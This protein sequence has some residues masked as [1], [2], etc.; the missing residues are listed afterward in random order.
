MQTDGL[1]DL[2]VN[3]YAGADFNDAAITSAQVDHALEAL[4]AAGVTGCLPTVITAHPD[5][6][7]ERLRALDAAVTASRLG[8]SMI[9]GYHLEG[10]FLNASAGYDGCHPA[11]AMTDP[12][13]GLVM[14]LEEALA[15]PILLVTLAPERTGALDAV[16][17][18]TA[19]GK[20]VSMGHSAAGI[21][22][23][24]AAADA[25][26]TLSTHLGNGLPQQ[27]PKLENALLAQLAEPRLK[28]CLIADGRHMSPD[29]LGALVSIKGKDNCILVTD[30]VV[31]AALEPGPY[32]FAG[33]DILL[34][35]SGTVV[36]PGQSNLAGSVLGLDQ[37]VR[38][39]CA[40]SIATPQEAAA[41]ASA[42]ARAAIAPAL[43]HHGIRLDSG[44]VSWNSGL[45]PSVLVPGCVSA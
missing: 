28:A 17:R 19:A 15:R 3:G 27:L 14:R 26:M 34:D 6:L 11:E 23:V 24:R 5:A 21:G 32:R 2:Q 35:E 37:A 39:V 44:Q 42:Q 29:A 12:D 7:D 33:M 31:A 16:E 43:K 45:E 10:P 1:F 40:W 36:R 18:L 20:I 22:T 30:A 4:L 41:M 38:N 13:V 9:P 25:G 8:P